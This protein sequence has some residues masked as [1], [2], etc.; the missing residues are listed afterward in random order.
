MAGRAGRRVYRTGRWRSLRR[1]IFKRDDWRCV[2][3]GRAGRLECDHMRAITDGGSWFDPR[4]SQV[5]LPNVPHSGDAGTHVKGSTE[6][7]QGENEGVISQCR[8]LTES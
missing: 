4:Q 2:L 1:V 8:N 6:Q 5:N 7:G 3:C